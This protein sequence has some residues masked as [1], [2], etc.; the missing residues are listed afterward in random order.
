MVST[1]SAI[2]L[3]D[4]ADPDIVDLLPG[5]GDVPQSAVKA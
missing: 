4:A 5:F 3:R 2:T 1:S